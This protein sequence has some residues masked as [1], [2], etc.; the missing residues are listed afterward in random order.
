MIM[1][2]F[3]LFILM[4]II[5]L[6]SLCSNKILENY[7]ARVTGATKETCGKICTE[8]FGCLAFAYDNIN[9][10][11]YL[12]ERPIL[13]QP[14]TSLYSNDYEFDHY[15]CNKV[16]P[17][18]SDI[19][20]SE[21]I[22]EEKMRKNMI[23]SCQNQERD[24]FRFYKIV[25]GKMEEVNKTNDPIDTS[26]NSFLDVIYEKYPL[27]EIEWPNQRKDLISTDLIRQDTDE[28]NNYTLFEKDRREYI[29]DYLYGFKCVKNISEH[30]CIQSCK[31]NKDC[32]GVE[33]NPVFINKVIDNNDTSQHI[34]NN[35][36]CPKRN[37]NNIIKRRD[38]YKNGNFYLKKELNKLRKN[39]TYVANLNFP[40]D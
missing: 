11:C 14:G 32:I 26:Q 31:E 9:S 17:I 28:L 23:Y 27:H 19:D 18:R 3:L 1:F 5:L 21:T 25:N 34:Y 15:R 22:T 6:Y 8:T 2:Q 30:D 40:L 20:T 38:K 16:D 37:F 12:S 13:F 10:K 39:R 29:G 36:C 4:I 24:A 33:Y 35:V 7:D